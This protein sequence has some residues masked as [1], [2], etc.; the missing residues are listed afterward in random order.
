MEGLSLNFQSPLFTNPLISSH[1]DC[2]DANEMNCHLNL[3][4]T[5]PNVH[6]AQMI[7]LQIVLSKLLTFVRSHLCSPSRY[8]ECQHVPKTKAQVIK[9]F[10][11]ERQRSKI[12]RPRA[13]GIPQAVRLNRTLQWRLIGAVSCAHRYRWNLYHRQRSVASTPR[14][15]RSMARSTK[16]SISYSGPALRR[17]HGFICQRVG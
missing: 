7:S 1:I 13:S 16:L 14:Y 4:T 5:C 6:V 17:H 15:S 12:T 9:Q 3:Q 2:T 10:A 8:Q 11:L